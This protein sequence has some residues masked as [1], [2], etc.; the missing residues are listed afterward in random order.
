MHIFKEK[1]ME[2]ITLA[3]IFADTQSLCKTNAA[4]FAACKHKAD[5]V[6]QG[7][8]SNPPEVVATAYKKLL[9]D[10]RHVFRA[11]EFAILRRRITMSLRRCRG[12]AMPT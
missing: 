2:C 3:E 9:S 5:A 4:L 12:S 6:V 1:K 7:A 8:F 11:I 10:Y